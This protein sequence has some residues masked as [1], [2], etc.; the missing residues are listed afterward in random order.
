MVRDWAD[1]HG[2][3]FTLRLT[4]AAGGTFVRAGGGP[5][6]ELDAVEFCRTL[7]GRS[8]GDGLLATEVVF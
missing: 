8:T 3:P 4:G 7:S 6:L 1:R 5:E 2:Q